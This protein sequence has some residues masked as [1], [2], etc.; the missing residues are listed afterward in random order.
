M[1]DEFALELDAFTESIHR[2]RD[3]E[4]DGM[5]GAR[6][7]ATIEAIYDRHQCAMSHAIRPCLLS[8]EL[9]SRR[10]STP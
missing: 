9:D 5:E 7:M 1:I 2:G 6:D 3:P 8:K 4:P 10:C